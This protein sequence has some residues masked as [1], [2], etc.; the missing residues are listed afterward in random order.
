VSIPHR[1]LAAVKTGERPPFL[2]GVRAN[3]AFYSFSEQAGR[4]AVLLH[5]GL[6]GFSISAPF[7]AA[8]HRRAS[9]FEESAAD[10]LCLVDAANPNF[11]AYTVAPLAT[12]H[13]LFCPPPVLRPWGF[14]PLKPVLIV[15][16]RNTRVIASI[17]STDPEAAVEAALVALAS[18]PRAARHDGTRDF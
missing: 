6:L 9:E 14:D 17:A 2:T 8:F 12:P 18:G 10:V 15:I 4:P 13:V 16:D 7:A 5:V 3:S 11:S 1:S